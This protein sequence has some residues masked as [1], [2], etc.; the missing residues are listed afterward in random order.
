MKDGLIKLQN[1]SV[2]SQGIKAS[3]GYFDGC[4][5]GQIKDGAPHGFGRFIRKYNGDIYEGSF[6][7]GTLDG[8]ARFIACSGASQIGWFKESKLVGNCM[9]YYSSGKLWH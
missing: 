2:T 9:E 1:T 6:Q 5:T 7:N 4:Y 8:W 3:L